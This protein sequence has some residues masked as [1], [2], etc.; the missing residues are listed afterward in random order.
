M[1]EIIWIKAIHTHIDTIQFEY[2]F[3]STR[4]SC[5]GACMGPGVNKSVFV[6]LTCECMRIVPSASQSMRCG[7]C[8]VV[9]VAVVGVCVYRV[10]GRPSL[11]VVGAGAAG[12]S[13]G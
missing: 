1:S 13:T 2:C 7:V 10:S 12:S 3:D 4:T 5:V 9:V 11:V 6:S 8:L